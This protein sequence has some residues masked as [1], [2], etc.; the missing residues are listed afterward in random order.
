MAGDKRVSYLNIYEGGKRIIK[1]VYAIGES[2]KNNSSS[3]SPGR[4]RMPVISAHAIIDEDMNFRVDTSGQTI[5]E[6][7]KRRRG[8]LEQFQATKL[9]D[10]I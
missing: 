5:T 6:T 3:R 4:L 8:Q 1:P 2:E 9:H 7:F 10:S